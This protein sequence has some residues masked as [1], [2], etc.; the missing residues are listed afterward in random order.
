[1]TTHYIHGRDAAD[2]REYPGGPG[3]LQRL[4]DTNTVWISVALIIE[5]ALFALW[6]PSGTFVS[7]YNFQTIA[8]DSAVILMLAT[9]ATL[10]IVTGGIDL[11]LGSILTLSAVCSA[12]VIHATAPFSESLALVVG[13][14]TGFGVGLIAGAF[15]GY[16]IA[17]RKLPAFVVTLGSL[18][19]ALGI[20]R[21]VSSGI[22]ISGLPE[23]LRGIGHSEL[24]GIP[25]PFLIALALIGLFTFLLEQTRFGERT[26]FIGSSPEASIRGGLNVPRHT[27]SIYMLAGMLAGVAGLVD[28]ARFEVASV[29][30]GHTTELIAAIA[31]VVIGGGSLFGGIGSLKGTFV[32]VFIP[33]VLTN[34]LLI[35][36]IERFWQDV[37]IGFMLIIAVGFDHW[38]RK[39]EALR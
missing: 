18:G 37:I 38:R 25:M 26:Y 30:T 8:S 33:V 22:G 32:G 9:A 12:R 14:A 2:S 10:V 24:F 13:I 5:I 34:G 35:G 4:A 15:N 21:L 31:A 7:V 27:M 20:A 36:G 17:Y 16:L 1:M 11:S 23:T 3:L 29:S 19:I 39:S 28:F 6:L